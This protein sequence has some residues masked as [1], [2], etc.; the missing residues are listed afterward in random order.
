MRNKKHN[1]GTHDLPGL[2]DAILLISVFSSVAKSLRETGEAVRRLDR[3]LVPRGGGRPVGTA[4]VVFGGLSGAANKSRLW[5]A[6]AG[7]MALRKGRA[8][9]AAA[10]G[11]IALTAASTMNA[12]LK[13]MLPSRPR[14]EH[15]GFLR[16]AHPESDSSSLPSGHSG[17]R[18]C[19]PHRRGLG[20]SGMGCSRSSGRCGCGLLPCAHRRALAL[21]CPAWFGSRCSSSGTDKRLGARLN[22]LSGFLKLLGKNASRRSTD[23]SIGLVRAARRPTAGAAPAAVIPLPI[24]SHMQGSGMPEA[25][26]MGRFPG[27]V[28]QSLRSGLGVLL[29]RSST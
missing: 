14:P 27:W 10:H 8:R 5:F 13:R 9:R 6:V 22:S 16:F 18:L 12:V 1:L 17:V 2:P 19:F 21:G 4:D 7:V 26:T 23:G 3:T 25:E 28:V 20:K 15:L 24:A 29:A 11:L